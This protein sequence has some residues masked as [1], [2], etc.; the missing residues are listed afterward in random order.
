MWVTFQALDCLEAYLQDQF[1]HH[2]AINSTFMHFLMCAMADQLALG[3]KGKINGIAKRLS[4][5]DGMATKAILNTLGTKVEKV[6]KA[7]SLKRT[8]GL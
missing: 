4:S 8:G 5:L 1:C 6:I 2:P 3:L 7:K